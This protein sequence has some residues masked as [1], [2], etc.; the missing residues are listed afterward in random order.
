MGLAS[1]LLAALRD[2]GLSLEESGEVEV[3]GALVPVHVDVAQD[4]AV[5]VEP[6]VWVAHPIR[7]G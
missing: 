6:N 4:H 5:D 7:E 3:P 1:R 2:S